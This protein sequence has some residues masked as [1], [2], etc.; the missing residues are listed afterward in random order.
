MS[1]R[2]LQI[3]IES[4]LTVDTT[5]SSGP[6]GPLPTTVLPANFT[7]S[8]PTNEWARLNIF[9]PG[10]AEIGY[11][12]QSTNTGFIE[13]NIFV[14]EGQGESRANVIADD[15]MSRFAGSEGRTAIPTRY[16]CK[17]RRLILSTPNLF[18]VDLRIPFTRFN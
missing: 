14:D 2:N 6:R 15:L 10:S 9:S 8:I 11:A 16:N 12:E 3:E 18:R 13:F 1:F 4:R 17:L 5:V 7:G